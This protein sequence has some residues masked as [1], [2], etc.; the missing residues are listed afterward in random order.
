MSHTALVFGDQLM[1]DNPALDG[2]SRVVFVESTAGMR[3][4]RT[5]RRRV[6]LVLSGMR[7]FADELR[8]AGKI[9]VIERRGVATLTA[10]LDGLDDVVCAAPNSASARRG[11]ARLGITRST[12]TSSSPRPRRSRTGPAIAGGW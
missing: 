10:G 12:R 9:E 8:A 2:A 7:H 3:R 6:H 1:R 4:L 5:H 11:V